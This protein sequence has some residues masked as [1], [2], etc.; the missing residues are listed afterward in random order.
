MSNIIK[1]DAWKNICHR[2]ERKE[3]NSLIFEVHI[4]NNKKIQRLPMGK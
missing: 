4:L 1:D 3:K 2:Y